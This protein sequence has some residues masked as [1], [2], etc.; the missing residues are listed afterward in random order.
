M[1]FRRAFDCVFGAASRI[2]LML[3]G[4]KP[5][6]RRYAS[7]SFGETASL[8]PS[9]R[10]PSIFRAMYL[11]FFIY[12][13]LNRGPLIPDL[14]AFRCRSLL[15]RFYHRRGKSPSLVKTDYSLVSSVNVT[16]RTSSAVVRPCD[17]LLTPLSSRPP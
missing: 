10:L 14:S 16:L 4:V 1:L 17:I 11:K 2:S 7:T 8:T 3:T 12:Q 15:S 5:S 6:L 9:L 13:T